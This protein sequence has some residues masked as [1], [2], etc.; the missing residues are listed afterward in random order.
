M[1]LILD[2]MNKFLTRLFI[3][4]GVLLAGGFSNLH[5]QDLHEQALH[6]FVKKTTYELGINGSLTSPS[7]LNALKKERRS[8]S[9]CIIVEELE[10]SEDK[11]PSERPVTAA[12]VKV[13]FFYTAII[14]EFLNQINT[15]L[16]L[17]KQHLF[18]SPVKWFILFAVYRI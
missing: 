7:H 11:H 10:E 2:A 18:L 4:L 5:A 15:S 1:H 16:H 17:S 14:S 8:N 13:G 6:S 3:L 12:Q 9:P